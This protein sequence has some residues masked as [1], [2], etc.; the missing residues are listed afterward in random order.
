[1][2]DPVKDNLREVLDAA[3]RGRGTISPVLYVAATEVGR[4]EPASE[5]RV[6]LLQV[7]EELQSPDGLQDTTAR[8]ARACLKGGQHV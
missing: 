7:L 6:Y 3:E 4:R 8:L 2:M 5:A 1:M